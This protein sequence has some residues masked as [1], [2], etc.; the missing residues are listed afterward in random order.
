MK[1]IT[2]M[3]C[4][5]QCNAMQSLARWSRRTGPTDRL[6]V[7]NF[8]WF[9]TSYNWRRTASAGSSCKLFLNLTS[10]DV[11]YST[12]VVMLAL[13]ATPISLS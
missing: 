4:Y 6:V 8:Q 7:C 5:S 11:L 2:L 13:P 12:R 10:S 9:A 3:H 1:I